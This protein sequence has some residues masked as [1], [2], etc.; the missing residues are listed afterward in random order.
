MSRALS[1][2]LQPLRWLV[3]AAFSAAAGVGLALWA[4][5][6]VVG[7]AGDAAQPTPITA[8][9]EAAPAPRAAPDRALPQQASATP[10]GDE[11]VSLQQL[12]AE[13]ERQ[14][15]ANPAR[16]L[17]LLLGLSPPQRAYLAEDVIRAAAAQAP[18]Q[19][20]AWIDAHGGPQALDMRLAAYAGIAATDPVYAMNEVLA[21]PNGGAREHGV[22]RVL[23]TWSRHDPVAAYEWVRSSNGADAVDL[24]VTVMEG[25]I[26]KLPQQAGELI[27]GMP[28]GAARSRLMDRYAYVL[29]ES[30]PR[31]AADWLGQ[32]D[33]AAPAQQALAT[34]YD[35]WARK[36]PWAAMEHAAQNVDGE[37]GPELVGRVAVELALARPD[38][39]AR[40]LER[41]PEA[42]RGLAAQ[43]LAA[44]W[45]TNEP[46]KAR[47]WVE[48][49]PAGELQDQARRALIPNRRG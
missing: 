25:Y 30:D 20:L 10:A 44:A 46:E 14:V 34:V 16:A 49:L 29:A 1:R 22:R 2:W 23:E 26:E 39:L 24:Q 17:D 27:A 31:G 21:L 35:Q 36:D 48:R 42:Y 47:R 45:S 3:P 37:L 43:R 13:L 40:S 41:V 4:H 28:D 38:E 19:T 12:Q 7:G 32:F 8:A 18:E 33:G 11:P 5:D 15:D 9:A 6:G